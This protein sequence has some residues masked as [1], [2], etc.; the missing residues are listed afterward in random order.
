MSA[1]FIPALELSVVG[2]VFSFLGTFFLPKFSAIFFDLTQNR[3]SLPPTFEF[4]LKT[5]SL[6]SY[7]VFAG[8]AL[9]TWILYVP[10]LL[11]FAG[12][13]ILPT[14]FYGRFRYLAADFLDEIFPPIREF[15]KARYSYLRLPVIHEL[16][17]EI[18]MMQF[19]GYMEL[20][21][22]ANLPVEVA[23]HAADLAC[24]VSPHQKRLARSH[25][26]IHD[27]IKLSDALAE[28]GLFPHTALWFLRNG[29][30]RG[31]MGNAFGQI[32]DFYTL[33]VE[34]RS[35][36]LCRWITP[37]TAIFV[38]ILVG[39]LGYGCFSAMAAILNSLF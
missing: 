1:W 20:F 11:S 32:A 3:V 8:I 19:C 7:K 9:L 29:E 39:I 14:Y 13:T 12:S 4:I 2:S 17:R 36:K 31:D 10:I 35:Q 22:A 37:L 28:S 15:W 25:D 38:G 26:A 6:F 23:M 21:L 34:S 33:K 27:G 24:P 30:A 5:D 16:G 18:F